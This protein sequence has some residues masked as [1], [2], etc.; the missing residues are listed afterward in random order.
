MNINLVKEEIEKCI[1]KKVKVNIYGLRNKNSEYIGQIYKL[2]PYIFTVLISGEEK[3]FSYA[4]L[5]TGEVKL[6]FI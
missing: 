5:V 3:S 6:T 4:D 1:G 2:Y